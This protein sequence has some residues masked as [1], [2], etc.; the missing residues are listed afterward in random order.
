VPN[1]LYLPELREMLAEN[2]MA[3]LDVF[4]RALHPAR[5][6]EFMEGLTAR[7]AWEVLRHAEE[8]ARGEIFGYFERDKQVEIFET[9]DRAE[10]GQ[11]LANL[12][13][14]DR[15]DIL[16]SV[17]PEIVA[18]LLPLIPVEERRNIQRLRGYPEGTAGAVM[19]TQFARLRENLTVRQA[20]EE[21]GRQVA[22]LETAY[23]LY[24]VD[25]QD[26]L[27]GIVSVRKL[28]LAMKTPELRVT[29]LMER[30]VVAV[31]VAEDQEEV[32]RKVARYDFLAIPVVDDEAHMLGIITHDD[33]IDVVRE[34]AVEDAQRLAAVA[35]L[36][37]GY[38]ETQLLTLVWKRGVWLMI[39]FFAGLVA[40]KTLG[41][42]HSTIEAVTW[43]VFFI[44]L[45]MSSGGNSGNQSA[46]LII[47]GLSTGDI[48]IADWLR[49]IRR[50]VAMGLMLGGGLGL[51]GYFAAV[52]LGTNWQEAVVLPVSLVLIVTWGTLAGSMLPL[53]FKRL[54][55]DPALMS[56]PA[57]ASLTDIVG[58][59]IYMSVALSLLEIAEP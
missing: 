13:P 23:Y 41:N 37:H 35:P 32:A 51:I 57:V 14:D 3:E 46:T 20:F 42:Y 39:L 26:H 10:I 25:D 15:V 16:A 34:E 9:A 53:I 38:L 58:I 31:N 33:I 50:E 21:V 54:G 40:A 47:T 5:T 12:P 11:L 7:E 30:A 2:N 44:P 27:R 52:T 24:V 18:E 49:V 28:I 19:T 17:R 56:N 29:D 59:V 55:V 36:E 6:A 45:V 1:T 4:C 48:R 43:L 8:Q 22:E